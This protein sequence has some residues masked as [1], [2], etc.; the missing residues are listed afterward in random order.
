MRH[1]QQSLPASIEDA[2]CSLIPRFPDDTCW[3]VSCGTA[4]AL[5]G[6]RH[7]PNDLDLFGPRTDAACLAAALADL[8]VVFPFALRQSEQFSSHWGRF[9]AKTVEIDVVGD[10]SVT[11]AGRRWKWDSAHPCWQRRDFVEVRGFMIP[12]FSLQDLL[13]VYEALPDEAVKL[14]LIRAAIE[15]GI[16][17]RA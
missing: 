2:I 11:R 15:D 10:F 9:R 6:L 8:T 5:Q 12:V 14:K 7:R 1:E 13:E 3:A 4:L 16:P 17:R